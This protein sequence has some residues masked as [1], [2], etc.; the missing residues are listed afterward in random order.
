[1]VEL[2]V[3]KVGDFFVTKA[4]QSYGFALLARKK[5]LTLG[6]YEDLRCLDYTGGK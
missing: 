3:R 6:F 2:N 1:M 5:E 4:I